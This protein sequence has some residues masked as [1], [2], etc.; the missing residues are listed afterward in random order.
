[1]YD[2]NSAI[3]LTNKVKN[4]AVTRNQL[5]TARVASKIESELQGLDTRSYLANQYLANVVP[6]LQQLNTMLSY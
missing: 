1:M 5:V 6:K 4:K 2:L 3:I